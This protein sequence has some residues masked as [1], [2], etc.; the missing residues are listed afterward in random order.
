MDI[1]NIGR[2]ETW[3]DAI[4][5]GKVYPLDSETFGKLNDTGLGSVILGNI[6]SVENPQCQIAEEIT[7]GSLFLRNID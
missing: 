1:E 2:D 7:H 6:M 3:R 5:T 4:H